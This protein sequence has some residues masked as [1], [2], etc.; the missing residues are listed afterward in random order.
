ME[1][2]PNAQAT[3][4]GLSLSGV[5]WQGTAPAVTAG[6]LLPSWTSNFAVVAEASVVYANGFVFVCSQSGQTS[7]TGQ[8]PQA[9][10]AL[11][12]LPDGTAKW[13]CVTEAK[14]GVFKNGLIISNDD[15]SPIW[16]GFRPGLTVGSGKLL[17]A[18]GLVVLP[19]GFSPIGIYVVSSGGGVA[20]SV[21]GLA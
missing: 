16:W 10:G 19:V 1:N 9:D 3:R 17:P 13:D 6:Q 8:G 21:A 7:S 11:V 2:R 15:A 4:S 14:K 12:G 5:T 20:Y 18:G